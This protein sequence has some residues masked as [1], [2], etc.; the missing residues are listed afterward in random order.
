M[1]VAAAHIVDHGPAGMALSD[2]FEQFE[3]LVN[4]QGSLGIVE[5][6]LNLRIARAELGSVVLVT[7]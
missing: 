1:G 3:G 2:V 4:V 5:L 7:M 6:A